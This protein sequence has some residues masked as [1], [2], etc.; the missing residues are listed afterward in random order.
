MEATDQVRI[1]RPQ[2]VTVKAREANTQ[3]LYHSISEAFIRGLFPLNGPQL[4]LYKFS[5]LYKVPIK[6]LES[7]VKD[8]LA[9]NLIEDDGD[10]VGK[11]EKER[12]HLLSSSLFRI[13]NSDRVLNATLEYLA[14]RVLGNKTAHPLVLKELNSSIGSQIKLTETSLKAIAMLNEALATVVQTS[15][16]P[17]E[18]QLTREE[19]LREMETLKITP[20]ES[21][22]HLEGTPKITPM[23]LSK[24]KANLQPGTDSYQKFPEVPKTE[25][26]PASVILPQ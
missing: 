20:A 2:G 17:A 10:L 4:S 9:H 8:G 15:D 19:I 13:G 3:A 16:A 23:N 6:I 7:H 5:S 12:L 22:K 25:I 1:P 11:L 21:R 14:E 18:E 26:P 24:K